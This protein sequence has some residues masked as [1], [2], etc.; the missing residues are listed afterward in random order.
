MAPQ[1]H[2]AFLPAKCAR[3][4]VRET[5]YTPPGPNEI[6]V[7]NG[8]IAVNP[9]EWSKQVVGD[10][11]FG[12]IKY[13]FILGN[14]CAGTVVEI[15]AKVERFKPGDRVVTHALSMDP[16]VNKS[17]EGAFQ[18]YVVIRANMAA[19]I[20]DS[21]TFES[22]SVVPLGASTAAC[23]L[24]QTD[25]LALG[26]P[27]VEKVVQNKA[28]LIWGGSTA[29]G[30]NAIQ[31]AAASGYEVVTTASPANHAYVKKLGAAA[32][33][34]YRSKSAVADIIAYLGG[35]EIAGAVAIGNG[36]TE[37]CMD[38]L[39]KTQGSKFVAQ[40]SFPWPETP[41]RS[42]WALISTMLG[43]VWWNLTI[44][45]RGMRRGVKHKFIFGSTLQENE[46]SHVL[47]EKYLPEAL[48]RGF[49]VAAPEPLIVGKGLENIQLALDTHMKGVS[50]KKV[51]VSL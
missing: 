21:M 16:K 48:A 50:A 41:P 9:V 47:Y 38:V 10:L 5:V 11:M 34:D 40:A 24:Y 8:A 22:A 23:G 18:D 3:L 30:S 35:K 19:P 28:I 29:V 31:L 20:P 49:F 1:N 42:T 15:G 51:V 2:A 14:D 4:A 46:V 44:T 25:F 45:L 39:A 27:S 33:F 37:A 26:H 36:S 17:S 43:L 32:A 6:V 12:W 13:P 7:K